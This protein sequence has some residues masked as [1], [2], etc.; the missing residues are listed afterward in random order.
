MQ[1]WLREGTSRIHR[2]RARDRGG[3]WRGERR[4]LGLPTFL[5][6]SLPFIREGRLKEHLDHHGVLRE[7]GGFQLIWG[8]GIG[9]ALRSQVGIE[10]SRGC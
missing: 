5:A 2:P 1:G 7:H 6:R 10:V 3:G 9:K 8:Q 4:K